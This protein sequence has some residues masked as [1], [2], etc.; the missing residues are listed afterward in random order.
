MVYFMSI[1]IV[2][3]NIDRM[4]GLNPILSSRP[5]DAKVNIEGCRLQPC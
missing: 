1:A 2:R 4:L 5:E 3:S